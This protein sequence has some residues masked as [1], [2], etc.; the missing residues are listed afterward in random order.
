M[1]YFYSG[2]LPMEFSEPTGFPIRGR[3]FTYCLA[4]HDSLGNR[5]IIH[6]LP[7]GYTFVKNPREIVIEALTEDAARHGH[8]LLWASFAV[9]EAGSYFLDLHDTERTMLEDEDL[10][11]ESKRVGRSTL[12][13]GSVVKAARLAAKASYRRSRVYAIAQYHFSVSLCS[14]HL[15]DLDP[16]YAT[17]LLPKLKRP[18]NQIQAAAAIVHAYGAIEE[19][20]LEVRASNQR[21]SCLADGTWN[22]IVKSDLEQRLA[23]SGVD[24]GVPINWQ[25]RGNKT[26]LE[27]E[28]PR[29]IQRTSKLSPWSRWKVRDRLVDIVDAIAHLSWLRSHVSSHRMNTS[30]ANLLTMYDVTNGQFLSRRLILESVGM[31]RQ[32]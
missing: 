23:R 28:K 14:V 21:P 4:D 16:H 6:S 13:T 3:G 22:P 12:Q 27:T 18:I 10:T 5:K 17:E 7:G 25:I 11:D 1:K 26:K 2:L 24:V 31:L 9:V 8:D 19:L 29:Q 32:D 15:V 20:G 30:R